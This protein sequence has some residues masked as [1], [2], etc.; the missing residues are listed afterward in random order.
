[1]KRFLRYSGFAA[2][3]A[4]LAAC[5]PA[6]DR[7]YSV[8]D[9]NN[10][11]SDIELKPISLTGSQAIEL[12]DIAA[13]A[14]NFAMANRPALGISQRDELRV[15]AVTRGAGSATHVR[16]VQWLEGV[17]VF[18]GDVV[19]HASSDAITSLG[20]RLA[21]HLDGFDVTASVDPG[22]A[23]QIAKDDFSAGVAFTYD[24]ETT[25]L[26][27]LPSEDGG[28]RLTYQVVFHTEQENDR[29]PGLWNVFVDAKSGEIVSKFNALD[30]ATEASGPG[31]NAKVSRTWTNA[32]DVTA[33]GSSYIEDTARLRTVTLK[34][35]TSGSG[36]VVSGSLTAIGDA[37][38]N[39]AHGFAEVTLNMLSDWMGYNSIDEAGFKILSRV[40]YG[41]SYENAFWDGTQMNYGDGAATFYPL[42]GAVDVVAH[43]ID[44]GFTSNHSNL[45]YS[46][47][48]GG[49]N[50][51]FSDI[52]GTIAE[53]YYKGNSGDF[54]IG[55]DIFKQTG[56]LRYM[57]NPTADGGSI[58]NAKNYKSSL[59]VHYSSGVYNKSF[60]VA[61]KR[62]SSGSPTGAATADGVKRAGKAYYEANA[63]YWTASAT[64]T[65]GC[66]GV[67]DAAT[68]LGY[69]A[70]EVTY[71]QQ[72]FADVG[73]TC[74]P[75]GGGGGGGGNVAPTATL[76]APTSGSTVSGTVTVTA[77][78]ADSD[79]TVAKVVFKLPDGTTV[80]DTTAPYSTTWDSTKSAD[81]SGTIT[82]TAT[83]NAGAVSTAS[84]VT[85]T[86]ANGG[87]GGGGSENWS[88]TSTTKVAL[89]DLT[90][91]CSSVTVT[92]TG[93][94]ASAAHLD[95][96]GTHTY[97]SILKATLAHGGT[98]LTAFPTRSFPSS[99][100]TFSLANKAITGFTGDASGTWT[101]CVTDTD[102]Y[103]DSGS[104]NGF[105]VHN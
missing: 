93:G 1:M 96:T 6:K 27:V 44:H 59:D 83:D 18:G 84:S 62:F 49:M 53:F 4:I 69:T 104:L 45:T 68:A 42:S 99:S 32:L 47:Q 9:G 73:V 65:T 58:D 98:T 2:V 71:L 87:G 31:G 14:V 3:A 7:S 88:A 13:A 63:N 21:T 70:A 39:D 66:V 28:A 24:R 22:A 12:D 100:G 92:T 30:T 103:G 52:A 67:L 72:S 5:S 51:A 36:T 10:G 46:G 15:R 40:H 105:A 89:K 55:T 19:A 37:P 60:C 102:G 17:R 75:T 74:S 80:T 29:E 35:A 11:K 78:A 33:S 50:E 43:E 94:L 90:T 41:K 101:L 16:M 34:N 81:G 76:T 64:F 23:T 79:G 95:L 48:S 85:V 54:D 61:A 57:C 91:V 26:V 97:R 56:A 77:T 20:G 86:I 25:E 82:A 38:E 8:D